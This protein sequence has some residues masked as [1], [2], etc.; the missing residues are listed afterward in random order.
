MKKATVSIALHG[1]PTHDLR[2]TERHLQYG[3]TQ[4]YLLPNTRELTPLYLSQASQFSVCLFLTERSEK[5]SLTWVVYY[6]PIN[7]VIT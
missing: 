4:C 6:I 3:I 2:A 1:H 5:P 7:I